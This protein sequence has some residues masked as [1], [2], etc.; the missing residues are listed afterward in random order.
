MSGAQDIAGNIQNDYSALVEF[1][2]DTESTHRRL[3]LRLLTMI[4]RMVMRRR[5]SL[6][7]RAILIR[8]RSMLTCGVVS[9]PSLPRSSLPTSL[10]LR[11]RLPVLRQQRA[12]AGG[13][14][15]A[16][17]GAVEANTQ[18]FSDATNAD[19]SGSGAVF[20]GSGDINAEAQ[21]IEDIAAQLV[22]LETR[23]QKLLATKL[24]SSVPVAQLTATQAVRPLSKSPRLLNKLATP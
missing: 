7:R 19:P 1:G 16:L 24:I 13:L 10:R 15:A 11:L 2:V 5:R 23:V 22:E 21:R 17:S 18:F 3:R 9:T 12:Q 6:F 14:E 4:R 20:S 8:A